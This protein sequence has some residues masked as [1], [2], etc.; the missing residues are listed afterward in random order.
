MPFPVDV[1]FVNA[2]EKKLGVK[3]RPDYVITITRQNGG[4]FAAGGDVW[5][6]YP[7]F[8]GSDRKRL[9]RMCNDVVR[10]TSQAR[11]WPDFPDEAIAIGGNGT[12]DQLVL[13][14]ENDGHFRHE[15]YWWDH[16]TGELEKVA[17][18]FAEAW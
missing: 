14:A 15:V 3:F 13:L 6:L 12:G 9:K 11:E 4:E 5:L 7:I 10:E 16:E 17:E 8:D 2:T 18:S 1:Q